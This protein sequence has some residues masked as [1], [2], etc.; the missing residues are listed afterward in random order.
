MQSMMGLQT[1]N[2]HPGARFSHV[3]ARKSIPTRIGVTGASGGGTQT[4]IL[5]AVDP[6][7]AAIF[8]AVMVS[9][10]MQGGCTC[11]NASLLARRHRQHRDRRA[12]RAE[13][14]GMMSAA[15]DWTKEMATK[16][17][18]QLKEHWTL[19]RR[20]GQRRRSSRV[21]NS[22]H[23]YNLPS[24]DA[25]YAWFN[26]HLGLGLPPEKLV[27]RDF[28]RLTRDEMSVWDAAHAPAPSG[29]NAGAAFEKK[30]TRWLAD[31]ATEQ[32]KA[33]PDLVRTAWRH[34]IGRTF[35]TAGDDLDF[36]TDAAQKTEH[37][38]HT[39]F[40]GPIVNESFREEVQAVMYYPNNWNGSVL[41]LL[42]AE[43][44]LDQTAKDAL[45][46]GTGVVHS[47]LF[48]PGEKN[49]PVA[50]KREAPCYT[51]GYNRPLLA[52]RV[53]DVLTILKFALTRENHPVKS[54]AVH[55][56]GP[57]YFPIASLALYLTENQPV[58]LSSNDRAFPG[59]QDSYLD[60]DFVPGWARYPVPGV[61]MAAQ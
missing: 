36:D 26:K 53:H 33:K 13:A 4:F 46:N 57:T 55:A 37:G 5:G 32:V 18:P 42:S 61:T 59:I 21:S 50:G 48:R 9:T 56:D 22:S 40:R 31:A 38:D 47:K 25:M 43:D 12:L 49:R 39:E 30:L 24:R 27:E 58:T 8:P 3:A 52:Q 54:I 44:S 41:V 16:G 20:A 15:D 23:N 19:P 60:P 28:R 34:I 35:T 29:E 2:S 6:R 10:A 11:E 17:F 14:A 1:W 51:Y 7:P 45:K